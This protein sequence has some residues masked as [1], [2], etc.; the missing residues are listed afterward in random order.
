[1]AEANN[2]AT[3][4]STTPS[5]SPEEVGLSHECQE[6]HASSPPR[7][8]VEE[9]IED[10]LY[11]HQGFWF[12]ERRLEAVLWF[13]S[14]FKSCDRDI[15][16]AT[17]PKS[18]TTWLKSLVFATVNRTKYSFSDNPLLTANPH[19]LV[20]F[21]ELK[22]YTDNQLPNL[23]NISHPRVF[24]THIP[25][26]LLPE[27]T[28]NSNCRIIYLC[29]N[30]RDT[31]ISSWHFVNKSSRRESLGPLSLEEAFEWFCNGVIP[32]GPYWNHLL[33]YWNESL[34]RPRN[35]LFLRYEELKEDI[36]S[37]LRRIADFLGC[38]FSLEEGRQGVIEE[39]V[40]LCSFESL[41]NLEVNK[42]G[43]FIP[44]YES[45]SLFRRGEVGDWMNYLTPPMVKRLD[46]LMREKLSD[47][48][49][50]FDGYYSLL[51]K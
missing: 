39:I 23:S 32:F 17:L 6:M 30:P 1:M 36:V 15:I 25:Y 3:Q 12:I 50:E 26:Q 31:F 48:G 44:G 20:P 10:P 7:T 2:L 27:T 43:C 42:T 33:G 16:L 11:Q 19:E 5:H 35:V 4:N 13:Q 46:Q 14:N 29:R 18:G 51:P 34:T 21:F 47:S 40:R 28:K 38:P 8:R 9:W 41:R 49:L 22:L 37:Q 24:A 45:N